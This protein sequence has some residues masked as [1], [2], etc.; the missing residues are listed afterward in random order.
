M[1]SSIYPSKSQV[2]ND[3]LEPIIQLDFLVRGSYLPAEHGYGLFSACV[4]MVPELRRESQLS[5]LTIPGIPDQPGRILLTRQSCLRIRLPVSKIPLVYRLATKNIKIGAYEIQIGIPKIS[6]LKPAHR[7]R[8]RI[9]TVKGYTEPNLFLEAVQRQMD[10]LGILGKPS[11]PSD[12]DGNP[13]RK[14]IKIQRYTIVG[15]T[16]EVTG[17]S[18]DDSLKLLSHGLG[19]K[20]HMGCGIFL[21]RKD[22]Q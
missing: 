4:N 20:R 5:I 19:G 16:T 12:R 3:E 22:N 18:H 14:T 8:S 6:I 11:I 15:F 17:L 13:S 2:I 7:L 10:G 21:P 1:V 9:V